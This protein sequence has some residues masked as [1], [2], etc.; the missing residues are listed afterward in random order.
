LNKTVGNEPDDVTEVLAEAQRIGYLGP[1]PVEVQRRHAEGYVQAAC[2]LGL[3]DEAKQTM[4]ADLGSGGGVPGLVVALGLPR[5]QVVLIDAS[6]KRCSFLTWAAVE[7]GISNRVSVVCGRAEQ[8]A[9]DVQ[10]RGKFDLVTARGFGPPA[11]TVE[12]GSPLLS[13]GG[14]LLI[15]EPPKARRWPPEG[16]ARIGLCYIEQVGGI[17]VLSRFSDVAGDF[18]RPR[19]R[20]KRDPLFIQ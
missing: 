6:Q 17:V 19:S 9:H 2:R 10:W 8:V 13:A 3:G 11:W 18:P 1:R 20:Q 14:S 12:C 4:I 15:S 5:S 16:L 7:L